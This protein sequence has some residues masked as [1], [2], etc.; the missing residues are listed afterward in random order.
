[1]S[2]RIFYNQ[3]DLTPIVANIQNPPPSLSTPD[4]QLALR[5][6]NGG[7]SSW[8]TAPQGEPP[9]DPPDPLCRVVTINNTFNGQTI[10]KQMMID[11]LRRVCAADPVNAQ[12]MCAIA[13]DMVSSA[14]E[15]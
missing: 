1:M 4:K 7:L 2:F 6:W 10:T 8:Q 5:I 9:G 14:R 11:L 13:N 15:P 3:A 12:Y